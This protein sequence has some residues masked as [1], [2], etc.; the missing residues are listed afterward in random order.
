MITQ[1]AFPLLPR[2][3]LPCIG[4]GFYELGCSVR[5]GGFPRAYAFCGERGEGII[6][7]NEQLPL[8]HDLLASVRQRYLRVWAKSHVMAHAAT[9]VAEHPVLRAGGCH[10]EVQTAPVA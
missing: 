3:R 4:L 9:L 7:G 6:P 1:R 10:A 5:K 2:P 8:L